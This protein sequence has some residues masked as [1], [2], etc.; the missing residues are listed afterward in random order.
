MFTTASEQKQQQQHNYD[1][2]PMSSK[3]ASLHASS[4]SVSTSKQPKN[5]GVV[6]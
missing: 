2:Y 6:L 3:A 4:S 1:T 5:P